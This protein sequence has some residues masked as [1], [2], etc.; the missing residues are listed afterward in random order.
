MSVRRDEPFIGVASRTSSP[1]CQRSAFVV[2]YVCVG[3]QRQIIRVL[4]IN[5]SRH[6]T[7]NQFNYFI[8]FTLNTQLG[9]ICK[10]IHFR[11]LETLIKIE[12][13]FLLH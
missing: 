8:K 9:V 3:C 10:N 1:F 11:N 2:G 4:L 12:R 6:I 5:L 13:D 7:N